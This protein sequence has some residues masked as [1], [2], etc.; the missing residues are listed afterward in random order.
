MILLVF[1]IQ[2]VA[3][4]KLFIESHVT[5]FA[6]NI[7]MKINE[8][9]KLFYTILAIVNIIMYNLRIEKNN[10]VVFY[11]YYLKHFKF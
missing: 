10:D 2:F 9:L 4:H 11:R 1:C 7:I 5:I 8:V 3:K 6:I